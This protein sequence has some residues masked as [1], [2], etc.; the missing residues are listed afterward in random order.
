MTGDDKFKVCAVLT[1]ESPAN[2]A[3]AGHRCGTV[4]CLNLSDGAGI[5]FDE[6]SAI[7]CDGERAPSV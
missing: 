7:R 6:V 4:D 2:A 5:V 3:I 1:D